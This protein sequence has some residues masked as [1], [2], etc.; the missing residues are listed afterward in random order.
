MKQYLP[1]FKA[2]KKALLI[3]TL[4]VMADVVFEIV[5]PALMSRIVD[6]GIQNKNISYI[7]ETGGFMV[8]LSLLAILANAGNIYY[9]SVASVGFVTD[10][11]K[12]LFQKILGFSFSNIDQFSSA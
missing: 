4:L 3:S 6:L 2:Y 9:S 11:R 8:F 7:L 5:Q 12:N 1:F 10:L